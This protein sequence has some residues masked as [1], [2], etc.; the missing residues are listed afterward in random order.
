MT[1]MQGAGNSFLVIESSEAPKKIKSATPKLC[2]FHFGPGADGLV[3]LTKKE[4]KVKWDFYNSDGSAAEFCGNAARC[5][6]LYAF[7]RWSKKKIFLETAAGLVGCEVKK[8]NYVRVQ[9]PDPQWI[10]KEVK[11]PFWKSSVAWL[12]TGVPHLVVEVSAENELKSHQE[13][14][15]KMRFWEGLGPAGANVT[16]VHFSSETKIAAVT[17]E[18]GVEGY[19]LACGTGAVAAAVYAMEKHKTTEC[20]VVMPGGSLFIKNEEQKIYME[21]EAW[22]VADLQVPASVIS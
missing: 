5:V 1:K 9:M 19:T 11:T 18:R 12:N 6:A 14:A 10:K 16:F 3:V 7:E 8:T 21:G 17:F 4:N 20:L 22:R 2:D 13:D 15:K